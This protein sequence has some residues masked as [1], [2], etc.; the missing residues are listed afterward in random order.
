MPASAR[1][2]THATRSLSRSALSACATDRTDSTPC[3]TGSVARSSRL[4]SASGAPHSAWSRRSAEASS[5]CEAAR[6]ISDENNAASSCAS[7]LFPRPVTRSQRPTSSAENTS[8]AGST[9]AGKGCSDPVDRERHTETTGRFTPARSAICCMVSVSTWS[10]PFGPS[11]LRCR[12]R[13]LRYR[14]GHTPLP[15]SPLFS[16]AVTIHALCR[17]KVSGEANLTRSLGGHS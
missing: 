17:G 3:P 12:R 16:L 2:S 5:S 15:I 7:G 9:G 4:W 11:G 1:R 14:P 13:Y 6:S 8:R 10:P